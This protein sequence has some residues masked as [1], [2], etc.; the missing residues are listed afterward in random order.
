MSVYPSIV[1]ISEIMGTPEQETGFCIVQVFVGF[2]Y[3]R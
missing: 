2:R 3:E 1:Y